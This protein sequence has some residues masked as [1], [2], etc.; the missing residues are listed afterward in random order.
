M[1]GMSGTLDETQTTE[2]SSVEVVKAQIKV[3]KNAQSNYSDAIKLIRVA[4]SD[5]LK[6]AKDKIT[7]YI[8]D[9]KE[10]EENGNKSIEQIKSVINYFDGEIKGEKSSKSEE[11]SRLLS[12]GD[13][14]KIKWNL[15]LLQWGIIF[16]ILIVFW[17]KFIG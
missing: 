6:D 16:L 5:A 11:K 4:Q 13:E 7:P 2:L 15:V 3:L 10:A 14:S 8:T 9:L 17:R 12:S 1:H